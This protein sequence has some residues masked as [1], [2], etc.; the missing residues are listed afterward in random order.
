[1]KKTK[2]LTTRFAAIIACLS[3]FAACGE[4]GR[5]GSGTDQDSTGTDTT[6]VVLE[7]S[8]K[9]IPKYKFCFN[10]LDFIR[11][12]DS[13]TWANIEVDGATVKDTVFMDIA[14]GEAG[15]DTVFWPVKIVDFPDG[16]I[17]LE[18]DFETFHL[19]GRVR[20]ESPTYAHS[21]T[22][23]RVGSSVADLKAA[24]SDLM[25]RPFP[26]FG[27]IEIMRDN[28]TIFH[29]PMA[30]YWPEGVEDYDVEAI[31]NDVKVS[32]IVIM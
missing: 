6:A 11:L 8:C 23:L 20:I 24:Y 30:D 12:G 10:G 22:G 15:N 3:L 9:T 27:V 2:S 18:S 14:M 32:R 16:R 21:T 1:M 28:R 13:V 7:D 25:A 19:L 31:P 17:Y 26:E 5:S 4:K 29:V